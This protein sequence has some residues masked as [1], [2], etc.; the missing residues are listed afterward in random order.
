MEKINQDTLIF[1]DSYLSDLERADACTNLIA[2]IR[3]ACPEYKIALV[4]YYFYYGDS[5]MVGEPPQHLL[6]SKKYERGYVYMNTSL[7]TCENWVPLT[8]VTDHVAS[9]YNGFILSA[10]IA[11]SLGFKK[12]FKVEYDTDFD[13]EELKSIKNDF[14]K[15]KDYLL[16]G[17]R[18]EGEYSKD[19]H[20]L[21]DVHTIG[22]SVDLFD[23]FDF[24]LTDE[25][26]WEL[27][28]KINYYGKWIE[29]I[30]PCIIE[31]Q[32]K[33]K[34]LD[35]IVY[36]GE[37]KY[38]FPN[39]KFDIIN[40]PS[41][42]TEKWEDLPKICK[43][44][45]DNTP[46]TNQIVLFYWNEKDTDVKVECNI[47]NSQGEIIYTKDIVL[48]PKA[49]IVDNVPL[50]EQLYIENI[51]TRENNSRK[52]TFTFSPD[53]ITKTPIKFRYGARN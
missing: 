31:Y 36:K 4:D 8:G 38:N 44:D 12:V 29:Y 14:P 52:A 15:F 33:I 30:I 47:T 25:S 7:G 11:K 10:R 50:K 53:T 32:R 9:I 48:S 2:Q 41:Y 20:Y 17:K 37:C 21:T 51:N 45:I 22:Y 34:E 23:G 28:K 46:V 26:W 35:G 43:V 3:L 39:T 1:I 42:W 24:T 19:W 40:S 18:K 49:W 27:C 6:D 16:H 13:I 5:I